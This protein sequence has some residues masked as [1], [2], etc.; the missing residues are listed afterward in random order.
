LLRIVGKLTLLCHFLRGNDGI[1]KAQEAILPFCRQKNENHISLKN[2]KTALR[3]FLFKGATDGI[4]AT[5]HS[6]MK[7]YV[8]A[9]STLYYF[10]SSMA[11]MLSVE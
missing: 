7:H 9:M 5:Y 2:L 3:Y 4:E 10:H 8:S 11:H 6:H 1:E